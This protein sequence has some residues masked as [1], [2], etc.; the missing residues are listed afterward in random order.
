MTWLWPSLLGLSRVVQ[1]SLLGVAVN[2][3]NV[4]DSS[5]IRRAVEAFARSPNGGLIVTASALAV[6]H[7]ELLITLATAMAPEARATRR[8]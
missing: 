3:V 6:R 4:R 8:S 1:P 7:R 5:E 2:P